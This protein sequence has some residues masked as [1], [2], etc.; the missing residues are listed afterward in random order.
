MKPFLAFMLILSAITSYYMDTLGV[1]IDRDM[2]Q[3][4]A[5]T[6]FTEGKHLVTIGFVSHVALWGILPSLAVFWTRLSPTRF[7]RALAVNS[8]LFALCI[9]LTGGLLMT[10]FKTYAAIAREHKDLLGSHQPGAPLAGAARYI[11]MISRSTNIVVMPVGTDAQ[12][13]DGYRSASKPVLSILVIGE[14]ARAQNFSLDG[15]GRN[16]NPELAKRNII[17]FS[18]VDSCG[19][20][21]A[22]SMPCMISKFDRDSYS[23]FNGVSNENLVDVL[24]HAGFHVEWWDNNTGDKGLADRI[25]VRN[26]TH[27]DNAE[28]CAS[29]ECTD[30]I[31]RQYLEEAIANIKSD[32]VL[33]LHQIGSHGPTYYLRYPDEF[34]KFQPACRTAEFKNCT[35]EEIVNSYDNTILYTDH[36]L[37]DIIDLLAEQ[38]QL[39]T[40]LF[41]ASDHGESLGEGGL[42]LHGAPYLFAPEFQTKVP[43]LAWMSPGYKT[44]FGI[45]QTCVEAGAS[46]NY[47]HANL[48][49]SVLGML[50]I[51][52][53]ERNPDLDVFAPCKAIADGGSPDRKPT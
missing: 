2:I 39:D 31:Y 50:D 17:N 10:N 20:A 24:S 13:G 4:V 36:F 41:Y 1:F 52:T 25:T 48:F 21:T 3:N 18:D 28:F 40:N 16:T 34:E 42:F 44:R 7:R 23:Y 8:G 29:G 19:T 27:T 30:G 49:H 33:V 47:S 22:V 9:A 5:T 26:F 43:M 45:D 12:K 38:D 32:T 6:T 11:K 35:E 53:K 15:Y 46:R 51:R 37:A 14:T